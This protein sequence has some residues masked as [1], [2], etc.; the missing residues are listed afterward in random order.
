MLYYE[1]TKLIKKRQKQGQYCVTVINGLIESWTGIYRF[2]SMKLV[3]KMYLIN[4]C[5]INGKRSINI[6]GINLNFFKGY[7]K[8]ILH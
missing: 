6:G 5:K 1:R 7:F 4:E 8:L 2:F 3:N